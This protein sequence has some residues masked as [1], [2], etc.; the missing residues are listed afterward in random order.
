MG[1]LEK[2]PHHLIHQKI[3]PTQKISSAIKQDA[4]NYIKSELSLSWHCCSRW[5]CVHPRSISGGKLGDDQCL[6][7]VYSKHERSS[8]IPVMLCLERGDK[9]CQT[10]QEAILLTANCT[11]LSWGLIAWAPWVSTT[12][13]WLLWLVRNILLYMVIVICFVYC[14]NGY[15][16]CYLSVI[17]L[18]LS[19]KN[20]SLICYWLSVIYH[21]YYWYSVMTAQS[22]MLEA[23][24]YLSR[25]TM[26]M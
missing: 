26:V 19:R 4:I 5:Q 1:I 16:V 25:I 14:N 2:G 9:S 18:V 21:W 17:L 22:A 11:V 6:G 15:P 8:G 7:F 10:V 12:T 20:W 23:V 24:C 3:S 13:D